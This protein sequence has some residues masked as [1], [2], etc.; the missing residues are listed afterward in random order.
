MANCWNLG[1]SIEVADAEVIGIIKALEQGLKTTTTGPTTFYL[2]VDSQAAIQRLQGYSYHATKAQRL[3]K[4]LVDKGHKVEVH[5]CPSHVGV[6][7]NEIADQ[8][9]KEGLEKQ[10][11]KDAY[12][13][14]AYLRRKA[15]VELKEAWKAD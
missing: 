15:K 11:E 8:L 3:T 6:T 1:S 13:S 7:G 9:A 2:F 10:T 12:V 5:W 14:L 4:Q